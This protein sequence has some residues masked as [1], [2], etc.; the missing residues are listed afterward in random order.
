MRPR[1]TSRSGLLQ[2]YAPNPGC[3][4]RSEREV[5]STSAGDA[6]DG[7]DLVDLGGGHR[8]VGDELVRNVRVVA[9]RAGP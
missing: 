9:I 2:I 8:G 6:L 1:S 7:L 5:E 3:L 4:V